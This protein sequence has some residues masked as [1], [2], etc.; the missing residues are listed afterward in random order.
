LQ[1]PIVETGAGEGGGASMSASLGVV[2]DAVSPWDTLG[3]SY[4]EMFWLVTDSCFSLQP[5]I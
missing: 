2:V 3:G 5:P 1:L 4:Q